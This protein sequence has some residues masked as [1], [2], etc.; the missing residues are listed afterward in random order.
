MALFFIGILE[1]LIVTAWTKL[2]T[3]TKILAS[4][5]V[6]M[7]NVLIWYYVLQRIINDISNWQIAFKY[8]LGCSL[9]TVISTYIF[10]L[11]EQKK[12]NPFSQI[13]NTETKKP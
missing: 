2:V 13:N 5:V 11:R 9:G 3:K 4:G 1:M 8:A 7:V 12:I 10:Y 6:T